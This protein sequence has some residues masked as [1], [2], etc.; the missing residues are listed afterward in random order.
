MTPK[1]AL[2][3]IT[4]PRGSEGFFLIIPDLRIF[5]FPLKFGARVSPNCSSPDLLRLQPRYLRLNA[6][7]LQPLLSRY[8]GSF[9]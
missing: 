2:S 1:T 5:D 6:G 3:Q 4:T 7:P 9:V 8:R